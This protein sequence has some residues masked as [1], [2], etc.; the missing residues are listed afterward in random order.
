MHL[1]LHVQGLCSLHVMGGYV[2]FLASEEKE[3]GD[4]FQLYVLDFCNCHLTRLSTLIQTLSN[5]I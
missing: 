1:A 4:V 2:T 5:V 3:N